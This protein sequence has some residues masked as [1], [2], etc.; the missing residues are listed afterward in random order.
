MENCY[1]EEYKKSISKLEKELQYY[2]Q[3]VY[4]I[5]GAS[6]GIFCAAMFLVAGFTVNFLS[7]K[8]LFFSIVDKIAIL[9]FIFSLLGAFFKYRHFIFN[10]PEELF[11][12]HLEK[13]KKKKEIENS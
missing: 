6:V 12:R 4:G 13:E 2:K 1:N 7:K 9:G 8:W 11:H 5:C 3:L 10:W